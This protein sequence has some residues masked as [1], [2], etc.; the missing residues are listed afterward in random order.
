MKNNS[1]VRSFSSLLDTIFDATFTPAF[2]DNDILHKVQ[3]PV[4]IYEDEQAFHIEVLAP[5][6]KKED[7]K[8]QV[9]DNMLTLSYEKMEQA[10]EEK[11][12]LLRC[13]FSAYSFKRSFTLGDTVDA[14]KINALYEGGVLK[15]TLPKK[16]AAKPQQIDIAVQ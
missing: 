2:R 7:I 11:G 4:N 1:P 13:E 15:I 3:P 16:E 9:I 8:L 6:V 10:K 14:E 12:K 5:G